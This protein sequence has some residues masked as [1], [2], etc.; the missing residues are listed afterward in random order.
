MKLFVHIFRCVPN[1]DM[2]LAIPNKETQLPT[3]ENIS[4]NFGQN[5]TASFGEIYWTELFVEIFNHVCD[6]NMV[7]VKLT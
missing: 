2:S 5:L 4:A 1:T 3:L 6:M 7:L